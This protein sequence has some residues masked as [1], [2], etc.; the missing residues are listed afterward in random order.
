MTNQTQPQNILR[1]TLRGKI[2]DAV[3][4]AACQDRRSVALFLDVHLETIPEVAAAMP[5]IAARNLVKPDTN[6]TPDESVPEEAN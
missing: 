6:P 2:A 5:I 3:R 4:L 1:V